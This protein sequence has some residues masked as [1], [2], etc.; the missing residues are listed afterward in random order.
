MKKILLAVLIVGVVAAIAVSGTMAYFST[1]ATATSGV[2][3]ANVK[4]TFDNNSQVQGN[5]PLNITTGLVPGAT[6]SGDVPL[7]NNG[8]A[9][10]YVKTAVTANTTLNGNLTWGYTLKS[11][12]DGVASQ[13]DGTVY[14]PAK[15]SVLLTIT[16]TYTDQPYDQNLYGSEA[17]AAV[18]ATATFTGH[19][20]DVW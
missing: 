19:T 6:T 16:G 1:Q 8:D 5:I 12:T 18:T 20:S 17:G 3:T 15:G 10:L 9:G 11:W 13:S 7:Y 14:I 2:T 4:L